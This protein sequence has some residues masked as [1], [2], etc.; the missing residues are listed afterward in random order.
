MTA[1]DSILSFFALFFQNNCCHYIKYVSD[2]EHP[3]KQHVGFADMAQPILSCPGAKGEA[4]FYCAY[5]Q[6]SFPKPSLLV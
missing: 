3:L 5:V 2:E 4:P 1:L 6:E